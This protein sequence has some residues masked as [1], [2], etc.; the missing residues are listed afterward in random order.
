M[1]PPGR[2]LP[3][4]GEPPWATVVGVAED[5][6]YRGLH[7][8][9]YD[10]YLAY[11]QITGVLVKHLMV[12]TSLEPAAMAST[13]R[14]EVLQVDR[15]ALVENVTTMER[16]VNA[17]TAP[18]RFSAS[19]LTI[20]AVVAIALASLGVAAVLTQAVVERRREIGVRIA[21]GAQPRHIAGLVMREGVLL[22]TS[23]I[24][25]GLAAAFASGRAFSALLYEVSP[26]DPLT[27]AAVAV[28]VALVGGAAMLVPVR[29]AT[30][31]DAIEALRH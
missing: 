3:P 27:M 24:V 8:P 15:T 16:M 12:R 19:T 6:R 28:F 7:D 4:S 20:L 2:P 25:I 13:I 5:V 29:R 30:R 11:Q 31:V 10:V 26:M 9:R 21:V 14:G 18:W 17:A 1:I 22:T 23:G